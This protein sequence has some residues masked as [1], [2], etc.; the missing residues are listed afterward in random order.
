MM[1]LKSTG[2]FFRNRITE[3]QT[4]RNWGSFHPLIL[5]GLFCFSLFPAQLSVTNGAEVYIDKEVVLSYESNPGF[6]KNLPG[7]SSQPGIYI[8][9]GTIVYNQYSGK[10]TEVRKADAASLLKKR[11]DQ[12]TVRNTVKKHPKAATL[13]EKPEKIYLP[14]ESST[15]SFNSQSS[16]AM[17][18]ISVQDQ[19][20]KKKS[21]TE[22]GLFTGHRLRYSGLVF[23][24]SAKY[25]TAGTAYRLYFLSSCKMRPPPAMAA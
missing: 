2:E 19:L 5:I 20:S 4:V 14:A 3:K 10:G 23:Q 12:F 17:C 9:R 1:T 11:Q 18:G 21:F 13:P 16:A 6:K 25:K 22:Y 8:A 24:N 7:F 15:G